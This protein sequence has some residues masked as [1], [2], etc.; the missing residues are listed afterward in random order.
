MEL[1]AAA[2]KFAFPDLV[3]VESGDYSFRLAT[4]GWL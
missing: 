4:K 1:T 3:L 2:V